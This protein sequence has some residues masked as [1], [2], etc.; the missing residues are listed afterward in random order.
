MAAIG[1]GLVA[2]ACREDKEPAPER[3]PSGAVLS[4]VTIEIYG[5][6]V[7]KN[8]D[9]VYDI[10]MPLASQDN[11][12]AEGSTAMHHIPYL[13]IF[14]KKQ[15]SD[16]RQSYELTRRGLIITGHHP[17]DRPAPSLPGMIR[18]KDVL[19]N[20][21]VMRQY[22]GTSAPQ[23]ACR[24]RLIGGELKPIVNSLGCLWELPNHLN[25]RAP[26]AIKPLAGII[27]N[28]LAPEVSVEPRGTGFSV[29]STLRMDPFPVIVIA[30]AK[31]TIPFEDWWPP[32]LPQPSVGQSDEDF[33]WLYKIYTPDGDDSNPNPWPGWL[34]GKKLSAPIC[35]KL[36]QHAVSG[37]ERIQTVGSSTCFGGEG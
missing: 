17:P 36:E 18:L 22:N 9:G 8:H 19:P 10:F 33:K 14:G 2:A 37:V 5:P 13:A 12:H 15:G 23:F 24:I 11:S 21:A 4:N 25:R 20:G 16:L 7:L 26:P 6:L 35:R 30:H 29:P 1:T 3:A 32:V 27:W 34:K 28:A 31:K